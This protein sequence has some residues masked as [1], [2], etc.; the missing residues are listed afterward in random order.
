MT[1]SLSRKLLLAMA[2]AGLLL[3]GTLIIGGPGSANAGGAPSAES[4]ASA[5]LVSQPATPAQDTADTQ[6][7]Q[8][9]ADQALLAVARQ[10]EDSVPLPPG[11]TYDDIDWKAVGSTSVSGIR[12]FVEYNASC[13]W[14]RRWLAVRMNDNAATTAALAII[15]EIPMWP[16]FRNSESGPVT[17][18]IAA[19]AA[20][21]DPAPVSQQ[22]SI[23]C[24]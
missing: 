5:A 10:I 9:F 2:A 6:V 20:S 12:S 8:R 23:N 4:R 22:V 11:G 18:G 17:A 16:S 19:A 15:Q 7:G 24:G 3:G 13:D 1:K 14:Y 21:G